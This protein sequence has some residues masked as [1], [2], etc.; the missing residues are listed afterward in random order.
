MTKYGIEYGDINELQTFCN[1][2]E[3]YFQSGETRGK[4]EV[5]QYKDKLGSKKFKKMLKDH[6]I[7]KAVYFMD[8]SK[9]YKPL[10]KREYNGNKKE[11]S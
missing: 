1:V 2:K 6:N 7:V 10:I 5:E 8:G 3:C 4:D 9:Y 11:D